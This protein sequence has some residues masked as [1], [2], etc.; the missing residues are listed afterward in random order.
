MRFHLLA[1]AAMLP[2]AHALAQEPRVPSPIAEARQLLFVAA[3]TW[4]TSAAQL[5]RFQRAQPGGKWI[6]VGKRIPVAIG[7]S[8]MAWGIGLHG[9][10][11]SP[12]VKR[13]GDM[14]SPA[15]AFGLPRAFGYQPRGKAVKLPYLQLTQSIE[16]VDDASSSHYN[17]IVD[18]L[19]VKPHDW[20]SAEHMNRADDV[21]RLGIV[22]DHN[23]ANP[24]A[25]GGSCIFLHIAFRAD[26]STAGCTAMASRDM[27]ELLAWIDPE[28]APALVQLPAVEARRLRAAWGL[29]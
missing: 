16:C 1:L 5:Q 14:K 20:T 9:A 22:V 28:K 10:A 4:D 21:Y 13:E 2:C 3:L 23:A 12:P 11:R 18:K 27:E 25:S 19:E 29:P 17:Q 24:V 15:G 6:A 7:R 8:G 26:D